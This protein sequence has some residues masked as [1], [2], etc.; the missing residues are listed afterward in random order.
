MEEILELLA[1]EPQKAI[2]QLKV[3]QK[4][5][6]KIASYKKE[7]KEFDRSQ[8]E[9]QIDQVQV[10]KNLE[11]GKV[12][13]MVK[14]YSNYAQKIVT[15]IS[16]F[17]IG[18]PITLIASEEN[19][20]S[21]LLKQIWKVNRM[22]SKLLEATML[23]LSET[24][25]A[26][27]FYINKTTESSLLNKFLLALGL[28]EQVMEI[29]AK[30]LDNTKGTMSPYRDGAGN[31]IFFM[32][33][34]ET[35]INSKTVANVQIW[36]DKFIYELSNAG[37][38]MTQI[39][40]LPHGFDR[41]PIAY[42]EQVE[43]EWYV[44]KTVIDRYELAMSKLGDA[45]DYSGH[46]I[47]VT[48]GIVNNLPTKEESGKHFNIPIEFDEQGKEIKGSVK[49][50]E[51]TTAPDANK[52]EL[53]KLEEMISN[54]SSVPNLSLEKLKSIGNVAEK[55]VKLMFLDIEIKAELK[56]SET[57]TFIERCINI[58][59]SGITT[60]TNTALAPLG[61][62]LYYDIQFNSILPSDLKETVDTLSTAVN[63]K[64]ISKKSAIKMLDVADDVEDE[65]TLIES[66]NKA[67]E[68]I[69]PAVN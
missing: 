15:T 34:Y 5:I 68:V 2:D 38:T 9:G 49:F 36:D 22:D 41:I 66:E 25:C 63:A 43:P 37:G 29:K 60:T 32:W 14:I 17:I 12:A 10:N 4:S 67:V 54:G 64:I 53:D 30:V 39:S 8:R 59:Q 21:K 1:S 18:K 28:K 55:T 40:K 52:L 51:A 57:R 33:E 42:D 44:V 50:L 7:Y 47:L 35:I 26:I 45:N 27:Q 23:K 61:K 6:D 11:G 69:P 48:E 20:L 16:A 3:Q 62:K 19:D 31:M 24:Q 65:M 46:P 13:K 56:R 58:L